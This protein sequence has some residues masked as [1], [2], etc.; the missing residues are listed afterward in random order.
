MIIIYMMNNFHDMKYTIQIFI[1]FTHLLS[2]FHNYLCNEAKC[3]FSQYSVLK[4]NQLWWT[5]DGQ[6]LPP[7]SFN[8]NDYLSKFAIKQGFDLTAAAEG[9][10]QMLVSSNSDVLWIQQLCLH[11]YQYASM[12][13]NA[14][15]PPL[16]SSS[17]STKRRY[18]QLLP[19]FNG[20][21]GFDEDNWCSRNPMLPDSNEESD[22]LDKAFVHLIHYSIRCERIIYRKSYKFIVQLDTTNSGLV[23]Q[24]LYFQP[25]NKNEPTK[26][27][28]ILQSKHVSLY[29]DES[30]CDERAEFQSLLWIPSL[31]KT[32][33]NL[34]IPCPLVGGF[35]I[36]SLNK[37][38]SEKPICDYQTFATLESECVTNEGIEWTFD[39]PKCNIFEANSISHHKCYAYWKKDGLTYTILNQDRKDDGHSIFTMV[40][41]DIPEPLNP[42]DSQ[43]GQN[44][45][46]WIHPGLNSRYYQNSTLLLDSDNANVNTTISKS[47]IDQSVYKSPVYKLQIRRAF[48][49]CDDEP[50][51]C[52]KGCDHDIR[53]RLFCYKSCPVDDK[54]CKSSQWDSCTFKR[55]YQGHWNYIKPPSNKKQT[56]SE[57]HKSKWI[58]LIFGE[59]YLMFMGETN[60]SYLCIREVRETI[61]DWFIIR[62]RKQANGCQPRDVCL[63]LFQSGIQRSLEM[64]NTNTMEFRLSQSKKYGSNVKTLCNFESNSFSFS[65]KVKESST[66]LILV[67]NIEPFQMS[68]PYSDPPV[69][70]GLYQI[71]LVGTMNININY[72]VSRWKLTGVFPLTMNHYEEYQAHSNNNNSESLQPVNMYYDQSS[73]EAKYGY[74]E[75]RVNRIKK[76]TFH[77]LAVGTDLKYTQPLIQNQMSKIFVS[78]HVELSDFNRTH[79]STG[80]FG[81][82]IWIHSECF[83]Q[84]IQSYFNASH[85][86]LSSYNIIPVGFND[87]RQFI[88]ITY[89]IK[90]RTYFCWIFKE[91]KQNNIQTYVVFL[92]DTPQCQYYRLPSGD[93]EVNEKEAIAQISLT[94]ATCINCERK[95]DQKS[96]VYSSNNNLRR[97]NILRIQTNHLKQR[98][99]QRALRQSKQLTSKSIRWQNCADIFT[100]L[101]AV[102]LSFTVYF[103]NRITHL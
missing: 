44:K 79:G 21:I 85:V 93:I 53:N 88:L 46:L 80:E 14:S 96:K 73:V 84:Q 20:M 67:R 102:C 86:C 47:W 4:P 18:F 28:S 1:T 51:S 89:H 78:C 101:L 68:N 29:P 37:I 11:S 64:R 57:F 17:L 25:I 75:S 19:L 74:S 16:S 56:I 39:N 38:T 10:N 33:E 49:I 82:K 71:R 92:F 8:L 98:Q 76:S 24:C 48:G 55:N 45:P 36:T 15:S 100:Y 3:Q 69:K 50:T 52:T 2:L 26:I 91:I 70:C 61:Q 30:L 13:Q 35:Q 90:T 43:Y 22:K 81:N 99:S 60:E 40:F 77:K 58:S 5:H 27:I 66:A 54:K 103:V 63:E 9:W 94:S 7:V 6:R 41:S 65:G 87:K 83:N 97:S 62:S 32:M 34:F 31:S 59:N 23:Y 42:S 12:Q 72:L 95:L